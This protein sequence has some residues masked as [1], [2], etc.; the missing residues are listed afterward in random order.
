M[1]NTDLNDCYVNT[2]VK[3]FVKKSCKNS[4]IM[5]LASVLFL[6]QKFEIKRTISTTRLN[7]SSWCISSFYMHE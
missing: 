5:Y 1:N 4:T 6:L 2:K 7:K 3:N